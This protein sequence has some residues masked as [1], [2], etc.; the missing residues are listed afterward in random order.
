MLAN[1]TSLQSFSREIGGAT[2][3]YSLWDG[4]AFSQQRSLR[5]TLPYPEV[6]GVNVPDGD[7]VTIPLTGVI[8]YSS[9]HTLHVERGRRI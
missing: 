2:V 3:G 7:E 9:R 6:T 5:T 4:T 8:Y 1:A